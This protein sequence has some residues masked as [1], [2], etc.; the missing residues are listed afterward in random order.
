MDW[1][2]ADRMLQE[3]QRVL[4]QVF[5]KYEV[6]RELENG[7][8]FGYKKEKMPPE[9]LQGY[10]AYLSKYFRTFYFYPVSKDDDGRVWLKITGAT[11]DDKKYLLLL[12]NRLAHI[13][14][15]FRVFVTRGFNRGINLLSSRWRIMPEFLIIGAV[16]SGTSS[17]F[18]YLKK[19]PNVVASDRKEINYF[20]RYYS[21]GLA[22]YRSHF[23]TFMAVRKAKLNGKKKLITGEATPGYLFHPLA[24]QRVRETIP[25]VKLIVLLRN[26]VDLVYSFY[27]QQYRRGLET[28]SLEKALEQETARLAGEWE[29][30]AADEQYFSFNCYYYSYLS[31]G[32]YINQLKRWLELFPR[33]QMLILVSEEFFEAPSRGVDSVCSFLD[34]PPMAKQAGET[35]KKVNY[36]PYC[37]I[38]PN[39]RKY[40][41]AFFKPYNQ[42]LYDFLGC[43]LDWDR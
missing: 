16:K 30:M 24:A 34:I 31:R 11:K 33:D 7:Y 9:R 8:A 37:P 39:M 28:L 18:T 13:P 40:L 20:D 6:T 38:D 43:D 22:W 35:Y 42:Q 1:A 17:L 29:K 10:A 2:K 3:R 21:R 12:A 25:T 32:M 15:S 27:Q 23:P 19:H 4:R 5:T 41:V 14:S 36:V 26:P